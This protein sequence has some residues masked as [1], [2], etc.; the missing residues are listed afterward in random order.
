M[1]EQVRSA[2]NKVFD[3]SRKPW[4]YRKSLP[5]PHKGMKARGIARQSP[6]YKG[7]LGDCKLVHSLQRMM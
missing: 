3:I 1:R 4:Q 5:R 2:I 6:L 7:V